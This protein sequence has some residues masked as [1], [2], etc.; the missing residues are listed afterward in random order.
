MGND[1]FF[2]FLCLGL[3]RSVRST[4][5][6]NVGK[7]TLSM[8]KTYAAADSDTAHDSQCLVI[9]HSLSLYVSAL[10]L[11]YIVYDSLLRD[12]GVIVLLD[13]LGMGCGLGNGICA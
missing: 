11:S 9:S 8:G 2:A 1:K 5:S 13:L 4:L 12:G 6:S 10:R 3:R 7:A